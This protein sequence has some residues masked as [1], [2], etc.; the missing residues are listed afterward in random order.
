MDAPSDAWEPYPF[1]EGFVEQILALAVQ[2]SGFLTAHGDCLRAEC[3]GRPGMPRR[4]FAE[5]LLAHARE[6]RAAPGPDALELRV[7]D[8]FAGQKPEV[9]EAALALCRR[10]CGL[11]VPDAAFGYNDPNAVRCQLVPSKRMPWPPR[12]RAR[13]TVRMTASTRSPPLFTSAT[14]PSALWWR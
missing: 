2:N 5:E 8:R 10:V 14:I 11:A 12:L 13:S 7:S 9:R 6:Y 1:P 3:F 4:V